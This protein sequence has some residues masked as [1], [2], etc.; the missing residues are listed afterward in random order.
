MFGLMCRHLGSVPEHFAVGGAGTK[1]GERRTRSE[2]GTEMSS[3]GTRIKEEGD[4]NLWF[5]LI[6][7]DSLNKEPKRKQPASSDLEAHQREHPVHEEMPEQG[8]AGVRLFYRGGG[9][10]P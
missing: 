7:A 6:L 8:N 1:E 5:W 2:T 10:L 4:P 3:C 9:T